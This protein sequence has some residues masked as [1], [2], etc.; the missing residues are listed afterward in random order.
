MAL[1]AGAPWGAHFYGGRVETRDGVLPAGYRL[2]SAGAVIILGLMVWIVLA[3][4]GTVGAGLWSGGFLDIGIWVVFGYLVLNTLGNLTGVSPIW[5]P[6]CSG[7]RS[8]RG[9]RS[10][11]TRF[12]C[13]GCSVS[14]PRWA[15]SRTRKP[16]P[17]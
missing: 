2:M 1:V 14:S 7:L 15:S 4:S 13:C 12:G 17:Q 5:Q 10:A 16:S 6:G 11:T 3:Y 9:C 8:I